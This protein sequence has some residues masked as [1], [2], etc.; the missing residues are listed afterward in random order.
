[1]PTESD[2]DLD[3]EADENATQKGDGSPSSSRKDEQVDPESPS[4]EF[5]EGDVAFLNLVRR[6]TRTRRR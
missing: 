6:R 5:P 3:D 2:S 4:H 1:M